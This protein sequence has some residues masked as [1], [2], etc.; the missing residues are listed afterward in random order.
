MYTHWVVH[1][2]KADNGTTYQS[3]LKNTQKTFTM[4]I[5]L[6]QGIAQS[7]GHVPAGLKYVWYLTSFNYE[8]NRGKVTK[9]FKFA[10]WIRSKSC[11]YLILNQNRAL[12][13]LI[14]THFWLNIK[15]SKPILVLRTMYWYYSGIS[16]R[17]MSLGPWYSA[18]FMEV[19]AL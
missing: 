9:K 11:N 3:N 4:L 13:V 15:N 12:K 5:F 18:R 16:L 17:W 19:S 6:V 14:V 2:L 10:C 1:S 8:S 7:L